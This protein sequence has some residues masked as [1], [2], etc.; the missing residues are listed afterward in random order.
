MQASKH[1]VAC[2]PACVVGQEP[3]SASPPALC[4]LCLPVCRGGAWFQRDG[5]QGATRTAF[6]GNAATAAEAYGTA[7]FVPFS[8]LLPVLQGYA[9]L[10]LAIQSNN[11]TDFAGA[12][13]RQRGW[14]RDGRGN[15]RRKRDR[16]CAILA[17]I[18]LASLV[19]SRAGFK[20]VKITLT[21]G[22]CNGAL[23]ERLSRSCSHARAY[24]PC[25]LHPPCPAQL[26]Q[27]LS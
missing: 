3:G 1:A 9:N 24:A 27:L 5:F 15:R 2:T 4:L 12:A 17:G 11:P 25:L 6:A 13:G 19:V 22:P 14:R 10:I 7:L 18:A 26:D 21:T 20:G 23:S 16:A 8:P